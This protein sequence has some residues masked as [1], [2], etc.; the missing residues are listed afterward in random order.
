MNKYVEEVNAAKKEFLTKLKNIKQITAFE[1]N[2]NFIVMRFSSFDEKARVYDWLVS[3]NI[4]VRPINQSPIV[5]ECLRIT[6]GTR[7]QMLRVFNV[8]K[9][10]YEKQ[11]RDSQNN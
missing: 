3:K 8:L 10:F 4:F 6:I 7:E 1:S 9:E 2:A 11:L 5:H